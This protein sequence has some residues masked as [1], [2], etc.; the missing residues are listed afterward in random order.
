MTTIRLTIASALV[1]MAACSPAWAGS[2]LSGNS[3]LG[4]MPRQCRMVEQCVAYTQQPGQF[5]DCVKTKRVL[6]CS[7]A[8]ADGGVRH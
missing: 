3:G 1:A 6:D 2:K 4:N 5:K 8:P 7:G